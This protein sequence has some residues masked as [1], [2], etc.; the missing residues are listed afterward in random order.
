MPCPHCDGEL[1]LDHA[2]EALPSCPHCGERCV[3]VEVAGFWRRSLAGLVDLALLAV[4]A[5]PLAWGLHRLIGLGPL[6]PD[7]RGLDFLLTVGATDLG[8]LL[9]RGGPFITFAALYFMFTISWTGQTLGQRLLAM[10]VI[11]RHGARPGLL[12]TL[13][14]TLA[15]VVGTLAAALGPLWIAFDSERRAFHDRVAG[16]YVVRSQ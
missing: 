3:P 6:A 13:L 15:Q 9:R 1:S 16:T 4:T 11:D 10:H 7:A 2:G 5:G 8:V 12:V 14:R